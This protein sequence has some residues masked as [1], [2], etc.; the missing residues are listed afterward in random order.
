M[1]NILG[2][3]GQACDGSPWETAFCC[4]R[5]ASVCSFPSE[6]ILAVRRSQDVDF[7]GENS[8]NVV[9]SNNCVP[10][11]PNSCF[12]FILSVVVPS[13]S[14]PRMASWDPRVGT[15]AGPHL[16]VEEGSLTIPACVLQP[17]WIR[18]MQTRGHVSDGATSTTEGPIW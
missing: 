10:Q 16:Q 3:T 6:L 1:Q 18:S 4:S 5:P 7:E 8:W 2:E 11:L 13:S 15:T 17:A 12:L 9:L 14:S